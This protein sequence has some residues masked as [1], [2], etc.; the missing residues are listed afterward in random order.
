M[1]SHADYQQQKRHE[2]VW[3]RRG[4]A[5]VVAGGRKSPFHGQKNETAGPKARL[6]RL[7][8]L[9]GCLQ[10]AEDILGL[11][12]L[13]GGDALAQGLHPPHGLGKADALGGADPFQLQPFRPQ[14]DLFLFLWMRA[15]R[16]F[17]CSAN[18]EGRGLGAVLL[19]ARTRFTLQIHQWWACKRHQ[20]HPRIS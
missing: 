7:Q 18:S 3:H 16:F 11:G 4:I 6:F 14:A 10:L 15:T 8:W 12:D 5:D 9:I 13:L 2:Q 1:R 20:S 17:L 19:S